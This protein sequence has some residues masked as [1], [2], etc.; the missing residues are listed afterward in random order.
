MTRIA[1]KL[2]CNILNKKEKG[3]NT[4]IVFS[5]ILGKKD[6][7]TYTENKIQLIYF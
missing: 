2:I 6:E 5:E 4:I 1:I 7:V 3:E